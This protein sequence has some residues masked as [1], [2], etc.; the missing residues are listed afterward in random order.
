LSQVDALVATGRVAVQAQ[1][2]I[3]VEDVS[4]QVLEVGGR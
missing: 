3:G 1:A 2:E 4:A